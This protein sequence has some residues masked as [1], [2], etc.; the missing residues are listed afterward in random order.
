MN[1]VE[2]V[3]S[4][5][6][7]LRDLREYIAALHA[8]GEVQEINQEVDWNLE[9]GAIIRRSYE[10]R[11]PAPLFNRVKAHAPGFRVF[12]APVGLSAN[13]KHA[14]AR[15]ALS[16]G[17]PADTSA[18]AIVENMSQWERNPGRLPLRMVHSAPCKENKL[19]GDAVDLLSF[20][21]PL[22]HAGDGGRYFGT[23]AVLVT[24]TPDKCWTNWSIQRCM[25]QGRDKL[26][27]NIPGG[28]HGKH[29]G[30]IY[31]MWQKLGKPM[32]FALVQGVEP[33]IPMIA[34]MPLP[35]YVSE[36]ELLGSIVG[37]PINVVRCET[38]DLDVPASAEIVVE[39][40]IGPEAQSLEG[41]MGEYTGY[42]TLHS[43]KEKPLLDC[44][45]ITYRNDPILP[46][47]AAGEPA[48]E[49]HTC[50]GTGIAASVLGELRHQGFP[51]KMCFVPFESSV[52]WMVVTIDSRWKAPPDDLDAT[53]FVRQL[54]QAVFKTRGG[55]TIPRVI[56]VHD[57]IDPSNL[58]EVVWAFATRCHPGIGEIHIEH[59]RH[60]PLEV[61]LH[62]DERDPPVSTKTVYNCLFA[63]RS[64]TDI[65]RRSSFRHVYPPE[66][67]N[68]VMTNWNAYG[69]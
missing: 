30:M 62:A 27:I 55:M 4:S 29:A 20:P 48:E 54:G 2:I 17:L 22:I 24:Q 37:E 69:Y 64:P 52:H 18:N 7:R 41:P 9:I 15:L 51:A 14:F 39:G 40:S 5:L 19:L 8:L 28:K 44:T 50:W 61:L 21:T 6:N 31:A 23:M 38:I 45:A 26:N 34:S 3:L 43:S 56:V 60:N 63:G 1:E 49:N 42:I 10:L 32:P 67:Q 47:C 65:P 13:P 59:L 33:L 66:V 12:G 53:N 68:K 58:P 57:D 36:G 25:L 11:A 46:V 35:D 16:L